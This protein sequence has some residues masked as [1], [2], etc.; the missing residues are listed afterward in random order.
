MTPQPPL[1]PLKRPIDEAI[2]Y[3]YFGADL[4]DGLNKASKILLDKPSKKA[5]AAKK[6]PR[7]K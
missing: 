2:A 6:K 5:A 3:A 4:M 1:V 7:K